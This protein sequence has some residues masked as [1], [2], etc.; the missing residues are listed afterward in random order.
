MRE[1]E[2]P[3]FYAAQEQALRVNTIKYSF[4]KTSDTPSRQKV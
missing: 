4:N 1:I 3:L 2:G